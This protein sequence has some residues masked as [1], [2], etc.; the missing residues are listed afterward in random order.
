M[1]N[2]GFTLIEMIVTIAL[3]G[4]V[5]IVV[6]MNMMKVIE[7]QNIKQQEDFYSM[8]EEAACAY[9]GLSTTDCSTGCTI[10]GTKLIEEGLIEEEVRGFMPKDYVVKISYNDG[11]K[12]CE[13]VGG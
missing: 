11:E 8:M 6:S 3:I 10:T 1:K 5:G 2:D 13:I 12:V 7:N 4:F 9:T